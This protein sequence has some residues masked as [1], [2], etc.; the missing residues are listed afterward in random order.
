MT[1]D[2]SVLMMAY[3]HH[4]FFPDSDPVKNK[5]S[6]LW[7]YFGVLISLDDESGDGKTGKTLIHGF[8]Q[9]FHLVESMN[10][11][12]VVVDIRVIRM[13]FGKLFLK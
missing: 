1:P 10:R 11:A 13:I 9:G 4:C 2:N 7:A 8:H 3:F 12:T 5:F 6:R